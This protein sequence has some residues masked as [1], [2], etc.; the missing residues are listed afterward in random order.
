MKLAVL[1][2]G[3][4]RNF[5]E[6]AHSIRERII[7][8]YKADVFIHTWDVTDHNTL[9]KTSTGQ[10]RTTIMPVDETVVK[11]INEY[12][13]PKALS[14]EHQEPYQKA[15]IFEVDGSQFST[16]GPHYQFYTLRKANELRKQYEKD[17]NI[18][19]DCVLVTRPDVMFFSDFNILRVFEQAQ[20]INLDIENCRFFALSKQPAESNL[21]LNIN[22]TNDLIFF[23][24]PS[25]IDKYIEVNTDIEVEYFKQHL[26]NVVSVYTAK[27]IENGIMPIPM[28]YVLGDDWCFSGRKENVREYK[29]SSKIKNF[30]AR[31]L[32]LI[33]KPIFKFA[34]VHKWI[35]PDY[36]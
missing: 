15:E 6:C 22:G 33:T 3:H 16:I 9:T 5:E 35:N 1:L 23:G 14:I 10:S 20:K 30:I 2:F 11:V 8:P 19:Y 4:L 27:E 24:K 32:V 21:A 36:R 17:N 7:E 26:I 31:M 12:Y 29:S 13:H 34:S 25:V 18:K 28:A